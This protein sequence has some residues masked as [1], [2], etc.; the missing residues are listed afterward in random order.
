MSIIAANVSRKLSDVGHLVLR[1]S[2]SL[3]MLTHGVPKL[4]QLVAGGT[5]DFPDPVG[6][7]STVS[8]IVA[9]CGEAVAP[10]L[11]MIGLFTRWAA[12]LPCVI[13]A[14]AAFMVHSGD[15]LAKRE[16]ALLYL[17]GFAVIALVGPGGYSID[18]LRTKRHD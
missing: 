13:M 18:G 14:V 16:L 12:V 8:L 7:G 5:S 1:L 6:V 4:Q 15:P 9:V 11:V 10:V 3:L 2:F 17:A